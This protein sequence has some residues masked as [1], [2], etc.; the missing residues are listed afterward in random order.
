MPAPSPYTNAPAL[1]APYVVDQSVSTTNQ[2]DYYKIQLPRRGDLTI[3]LS[4]L[5]ANAN[6]SVLDFD[7]NAL[8][9]V[10]D[11]N[12]TG[13]TNDQVARNL[14]PGIYYIKVANA[15]SGTVNYRLTV[16]TAL[17]EVMPNLV[18]RDNSSGFFS[19]QISPVD[20]KILRYG[21]GQS[22]TPDAYALP[23]DLDMDGEGD[24][25]LQNVSNGVLGIWYMRG[26]TLKNTAILSNTVSPPWSV[27]GIADFDG[28][29]QNDIVWRDISTG[30]NGVWLMEDGGTTIASI[31]GLPSATTN[32]DIQSVADF[33][34]DGDP[35][36][37]WVDATN[38]VGG[39]W[40]MEGTS[41]VS[42][43]SFP[44]SNFFG[45][46]LAGVGNY[47]GT[48]RPDLLWYS[49]SL[50]VVGSW[51]MTNPS[52]ISYVGT[53]PQ[54]A[55]NS[56]TFKGVR[57]QPN[58][59]VN[60][61][62]TVT[63]PLAGYDTAIR[64]FTFE[65]D[66][67]GNLNKT[68]EVKFVDI[69]ADDTFRIEVK[70]VDS[71]NNE[72]LL[73][74]YDLTA[75]SSTLTQQFSFNVPGP[76]AQ[77]FVDVF[78]VDQV[79]GDGTLEVKTVS[80]SQPQVVFSNLSFNGN[81]GS[82]GTV[83]V[84]LSSAPSSN[85]NTIFVG[86]NF[87]VV[88]TDNDLQNGT[89]DRLTFTT[90]NWNQPKTIW[91]LAEVDGVSTNRSS[92][93]VINYGSLGGSGDSG[94]YSIGT[95]TNT[96]SPNL[97]DF[98]IELDFRNDTTGFWNST[99]RAIAQSAAD[100]WADRIANEWSGLTLNNTL[101]RI[102]DSGDYSNI[103]FNTK[104]YVDDLVIFVDTINTTTAGGYGKITYSIGGW[105]YSPSIKPRVGQI[106]I[107]SSVGNQFL[108]NAVLH[109]IG[110]TTWQVTQKGKR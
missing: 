100:T 92:G 20:K 34:G 40:E 29:G 83:Q 59:F 17:E 98:N 33:D 52:T 81:E 53:Y 55:A 37:F 97:T 13:T 64:R 72:T 68:V 57:E 90:S 43:N 94:S 8:S 75:T 30:D 107:A 39:W 78:R 84:T 73:T 70:S 24:V 32:W 5:D 42:S 35:D 23:G 105:A 58:Y 19:W 44:I 18:V 25:F 56:W 61:T 49:Y 69:D 22:L 104:R 109:E 27:R 2:E 28:D 10:L 62:S 16:T 38:A 15:T 50:G 82:T 88:D 67:S 14:D 80:A 31:V 85:V 9:P 77:A 51:I 11:S 4:N 79:S 101:F 110:H 6:L 89:Q 102:N 108:Y 74:A 3:L 95:V 106:A 93:N 48:S 86:G 60:N 47:G 63:Q 41:Q 12:N 65:K 87:L 1:Y 76:N 103:G 36:I 71:S 45:W 54:V 46:T 21:F 96:Y 99:R 91:F 26:N 7:G 66:G